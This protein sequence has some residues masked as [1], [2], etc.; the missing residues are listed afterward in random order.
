MPQI[1]HQY[2]MAQAL[3]LARNG[4]Y[5]THPN[6]RVGCVIVKDAKLVSQGWHEF[7]GGPHAE[8]NATGDNVIPPG[9]DIYITLE[10]CSHHGRTPPCV[11]ALIK[12]KPSRVIIAMRDPNPQVA[13]A[14][15]AKLEANSVKVIEGIME[16]EARSLNPGFASRFEKG[17]PFLRLKMA[18]S[19]DGRTALKNGESKWITG[20]SARLEV[21]RLRA[22]SSAILTSAKTVKDDNPLLNLRLSKAD[23]GQNIEVRQP[24]RVI[25]DSKLQLSG[26]EKIFSTGG[27]IWIYTLNSSPFA[28]ERM[29][30]AGAQVAILEDSGPGRINLTKLMAHLAERGIN[31]VHTECGQTLA[32]ALIQE[33]LV[34]E[35]KLYMAPK[36][37]GNRSIGAFDLGQVMNMSDSVK[38]N[39]NQVR[40]VG[41]DLSLTLSL[42]SNTPARE[43]L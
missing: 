14:G 35:I 15:V 27:E 34:D 10:P 21:Q 18:T 36:L 25:I 2:W 13:G 31:E 5:S 41:E 7:T 4:L 40:M 26:K 23:L 17:R 42:K 32:G 11:E 33:R 38:C 19:L 30:A 3:R 39:I 37:L 9:C 8:V 1:N 20:E 24:I 22:R 28:I 43:L 16:S 29:V 12:L 6:P